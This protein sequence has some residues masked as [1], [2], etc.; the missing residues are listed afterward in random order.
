MMLLVV[1]LVRQQN[2]PRPLERFL[3]SYVA[4]QPGVDHQLLLALK[5]FTSEAEIGSCVA[6]VRS[7]G[8]EAEYLALEDDGLDLTAYA[9][10]VARVHADRY[11]FLNSFSR[12]L[13]DRWLAHLSNALN[14][15]DVELAGATGSWNSHRDYRRYH[16]G[17][18]SGYDGVFH[19]RERTRLGFL[20]LVRQHHPEKRDNG[21]LAFKTAAAIDLIRER[22]RF[23]QFPAHHLRT[24]AFIASRELMLAVGFP[25]IRAKRD[26]YRLESGPASF[27]GR[28]ADRGKRTLVVGRDGLTYAPDNWAQSLTFWQ[29]TQPNLLVAD[30][31]TDD[32]EKAGAELRRLLSQLAWGSKARP[33]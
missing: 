27:T 29:D 21:R 4:H 18:R 24:N 32:Y 25:K 17:L 14:E 5:G 13:A 7:C 9:R 2:G 23:D 3:D 6:K 1:H 28:V 31:Q 22:N 8:V 16:L 30:N 12:I 33:A 19:D 26:A 11:C 20:E 15:P 10:A